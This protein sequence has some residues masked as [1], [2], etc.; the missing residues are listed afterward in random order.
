[1]STGKVMASIFWDAEGVFLVDYL[2]KSHTITGAYFADLLRQ[3]QEK[4]EQIQHGKL[5]RGVF[6]HQNNVPAHRSTVAMAAIQNCG[7]ELVEHPLYS[8][9]L[10]PSDYYLFQKIQKELGGHPF[11]R[12]DVMN[13]V[14]HFLRDQNGDFYTE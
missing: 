2:D 8:H 14:D 10:A 5:P 6:F 7:F 1:M 13:A 12:D 11:A 4:I 3:L 9:D